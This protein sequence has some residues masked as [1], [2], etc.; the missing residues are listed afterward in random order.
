MQ[1]VTNEI[2]YKYNQELISSWCNLLA[3]TLLNMICLTHPMWDVIDVTLSLTGLDFAG[4]DLFD[5]ET[6]IELVSKRAF[7]CIIICEKAAE[8]THAPP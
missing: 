2:C 7:W 5:T 1:N 8:C 3:K 4:R 6:W